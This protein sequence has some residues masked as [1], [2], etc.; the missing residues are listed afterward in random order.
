[1]KCMCVAVCLITIDRSRLIF[2]GLGFNY[3][4]PWRRILNEQNN[5]DISD[6]LNN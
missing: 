6:E 2:P 4:E 3:S 1:V 5:F